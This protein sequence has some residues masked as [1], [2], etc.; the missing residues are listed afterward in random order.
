MGMQFTPGEKV[1]FTYR[2]EQW[3][4]LPASRGRLGGYLPNWILERAHGQVA[5]VRYTRGGHLS[6]YYFGEDEDWIFLRFEEP[7]GLGCYVEAGDQELRRQ[8]WHSSLPPAEFAVP[9][10]S[11][12]VL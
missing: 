9:A 6:S 7:L 1:R 3:S 4:W 5:R 12:Q 10:S 11:L 2:P 8:G